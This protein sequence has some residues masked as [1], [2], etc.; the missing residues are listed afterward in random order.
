MSIKCFL[1]L[2]GVL[3]DFNRGALEHH[4]LKDPYLDPKNHGNWHMVQMLP[5]TEKEFWDPL[6]QSFWAGLPW[7]PDGEL[8]LGRLEYE[9]GKERI[10]LLTSPCL[11]PG[12]AEG[13][14][15]WIRKH[16]PAYSRR[17]LIGAC[18][19]F[20]AGPSKYLVDDSDSNILKFGEHGGPTILIPRLWNSGYG[21]DPLRHLSHYFTGVY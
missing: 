11:T 7:M 15:D 3:V 17:V 10:C 12:C 18:K 13:K 20:L 1:D 21:R 2:D 5:I 8:I 14:M 16:M 19:E 9:F 6:G 4:R